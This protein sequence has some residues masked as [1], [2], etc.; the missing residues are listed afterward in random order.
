[1]VFPLDD[2]IRSMKTVTIPREISKNG[3]LIVLSRREYE[4]MK[5]SM[6]PT[7]FLK[8]KAATRLDRRVA[9]SL[10]EHRRGLTKRIRSLA[11][12]MG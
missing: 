5:A 4:R 10:D 12:L 2:T 11:D 3:D 9:R 7:Q 6:V 8:G 1:M